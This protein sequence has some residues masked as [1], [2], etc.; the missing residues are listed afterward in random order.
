V[1]RRT[2]RHRRAPKDS[3]FVANAEYT[4]KVTSSDA[5]GA[6][7]VDT[8]GANQ[9][10]VAADLQHRLGAQAAITNVTQAR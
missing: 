7:L 3:F 5:V 4:T 1:P 10:A 8:G 9:S 2:F 6:F